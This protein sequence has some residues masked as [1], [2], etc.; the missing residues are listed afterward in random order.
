MSS[1]YQTETGALISLLDTLD[2]DPRAVAL[3]EHT[4][5]LLALQPGTAV[6]DVGCG[7]GRAAAELADRGVTALGIDVS[8]DM[9]AVAR[10]R[11][12]AAEF[13]YGDAHDLPLADGELAGY[14]ADKVFHTL[15]DPAAAM[16]EARRVLAP[17]GRAVLIGQDW[18]TFVIDSSDPELTR[19]IV[20]ARADQ[21]RAPRVARRYRALLLDAG[22]TDVTAEVRTGVYTGRAMLSAAT[23]LAEGARAA[24]AVTE[25]QAESWI[26]DQRRRAEEDRF[27]LAVPM[28]VAAGTRA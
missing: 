14:R 5:D 21:L 16:E 6:A 27:F 15:E 17:G 23:N 22:F 8:E 7:A 10:D 26:A 2:K 24:G 28:F 19:T 20:H 4:Y 1:R 25:D 13:R 18:D 9:L 3:R 12:P 11:W